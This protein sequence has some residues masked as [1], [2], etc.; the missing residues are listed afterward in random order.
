MTSLLTSFSIVIPAQLET[1]C[2]FHGRHCPLSSLF[3][4]KQCLN[5]IV[6][7]KGEEKSLLKMPAHVSHV[8]LENNRSPTVYLMSVRKNRCQP[9]PWD[10]CSTHKV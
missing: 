8:I 10:T 9:V 5:S 3:I 6:I 2:T 7:T 1:M 4:W